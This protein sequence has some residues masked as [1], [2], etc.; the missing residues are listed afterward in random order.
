MNA[1][2]WFH[3]WETAVYAGRPCLCL[4]EVL[5]ASGSLFLVQNT[6]EKAPPDSIPVVFDLK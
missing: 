1:L 5:K 6:E 3:P 4:S 2:Q